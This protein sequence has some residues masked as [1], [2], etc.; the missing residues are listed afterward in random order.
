M[1]ASFAFDVKSETMDSI[2]I[3][4]VFLVICLISL[5]A[6]SIRSQRFDL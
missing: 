2:D 6:L 1:K 5:G 3:F 4:R